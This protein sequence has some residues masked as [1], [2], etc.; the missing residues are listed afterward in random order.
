MLNELNNFKLKDEEHI[1]FCKFWLGYNVK[2]LII[3]ISSFK[4]EEIL[5]LI[6]AELLWS[7]RQN[8]LH[9]LTGRYNKL[10]RQREWDLIQEVIDGKKELTDLY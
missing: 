6:K 4:E 8:I 3:I 10:C 9:R 7:K 2:Q 5:W 1:S